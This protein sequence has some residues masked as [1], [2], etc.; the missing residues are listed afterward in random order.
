MMLGTSSLD[1]LRRIAD[2]ANDVLSAYTPGAF[3]LRNDV[4]AATVPLSSS[5]PLSVV[6]PP[7]AWFPVTGV[8]GAR[9]YTR[10]GEFHVG[11]DGTLRTADDARAIGFAHD[12]APALPLS[13][14]EPDRALGRCTDVR[15]E[16]DGTLAYTRASIDPKTRERTVERVTAGRIALARFP[17][18][19][20]PER[21][22]AAHVNGIPGVVPHLGTP[23]DGVFGALATYSRDRGSIDIDASLAKLAE[24]YLSFS[25]LQ[26]SHKASGSVDKAV[27]DLLK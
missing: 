5:D 1:A 17:A 11:D 19:S 24:A 25:A 7:G 9:T 26:A 12:G 14:P 13:L 2:R 6:A 3:P 20:A 8:S 21:I 10:A 27:M 15:I 16:S 23:A 4:K 18:G 22:D